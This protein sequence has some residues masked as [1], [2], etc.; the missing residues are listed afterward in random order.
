METF[1]IEKMR[2]Q[3]SEHKDI[4][5]E[6]R[7]KQNQKYDTH[8]SHRIIKNYAGNKFC[9][10]HRTYSHSTQECREYK[11]SKLKNDKPN[12]NN[13][14]KKTFSINLPRCKP[15]TIEIRLH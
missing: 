4:M 9:K 12:K 13:S 11:K 6:F 5:N 10:F 14:E 15:K 7:E 8:P 1:I 3:F 2:K